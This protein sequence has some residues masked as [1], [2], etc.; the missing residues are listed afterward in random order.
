MISVNSPETRG[1]TNRKHSPQPVRDKLGWS[2]WAG[3][4]VRGLKHVRLHND[5][6][7]HVHTSRQGVFLV[8]GLLVRVATCVKL[9]DLC[10]VYNERGGKPLRQLSLDIIH[11]IFILMIIHHYL[12]FSR[13]PNWVIWIAQLHKRRENK[14]IHNTSSIEIGWRGTSRRVCVLPFQNYLH[15]SKCGRYFSPDHRQTHYTLRWKCIWSPQRT[16]MPDH[17]PA[18]WI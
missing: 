5:V 15:D 1:K 8:N 6:P 10:T 14:P 18:L 3:T 9:F 4:L 16:E 2:A 7:P 12:F 17:I 11:F 13:L